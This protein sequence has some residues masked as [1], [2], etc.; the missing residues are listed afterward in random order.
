MQ[1]NRRCKMAARLGWT[2]LLFSTVAS[3]SVP[4]PPAPDIY[5]PRSDVAGGTLKVA[6][7]G[8]SLGHSHVR[9]EQT[10]LGDIVSLVGAG[11]I[12]HQGDAGE[13]LY[14][15]CYT[16]PEAQQSGRVWILADGE[17]G[18]PEHHITGLSAALLPQATPT[19]DC[20]A[21]RSPFTA[22]TTQ[23]ECTDG[24]QGDLTGTVAVRFD[25]GHVAMLRVDQ[26]T[27]C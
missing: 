3:P 21:L 4:P 7:S 16:I 9:F 13:S 26:I 17:M 2:A 12:A 22:K 20:P 23:P 11:A 18:G 25:H 8:F 6:P 1:S 24:T 14:W 10:T 15:I 19:A 5:E 27:T